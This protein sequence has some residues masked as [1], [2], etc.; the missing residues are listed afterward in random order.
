MRKKY[1]TKIFNFIKFYRPDVD[2]G[3]LIS[4][5]D[6]D[7]DKTMSTN[8]NASSGSSSN[9]SGSIPAGASL[10][11]PAAG[12]S[13][14]A[15][16][17]ESSNAASTDKS[18]KMKIKRMKPGSRG[19]VE[20]KLEIVQQSESAEGSSPV[21]NGSPDP[22]GLSAAEIVAAVKQNVKSSGSQ[23][24]AAASPSSSG[25]NK[26]RL[27]STTSVAGSTSAPASN[28][29]QTAPAAAAA[30][31]KSVTV[32][33]AGT[34]NQSAGKQQ[35]AEKPSNGNS[36]INVAKPA[37]FTSTAVIPPN[38]GSG[39]GV[40]GSSTVATP[41]ASGTGSATDQMKVNSKP[42]QN[43]AGNTN[44]PIYSPQST[45]KSSSSSGGG[46]TNTTGASNDQ[47][48]AKKQKV[49]DSKIYLL[50]LE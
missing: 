30:T 38:P 8:P 4:G 17:T 22:I 32:T 31:K 49:R 9:Q 14:T 12:G 28:P 41:T 35:A 27:S 10:S 44:K 6:A 46:T 47:P 24:A 36:A 3:N 29:S 16:L 19:N 18:L 20:G 1:L 5:L 40:A 25:G 37:S 50:H 23:V 33:G 45:S 2:L 39:A 34:I 42:V 11:V 15:V 43:L 26:V 21:S 13:A 7:I 48:P